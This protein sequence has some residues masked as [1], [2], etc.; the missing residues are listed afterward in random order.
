MSVSS[1]A[2]YEPVI[3]AQAGIHL[4]KAFREHLTKLLPFAGGRIAVALSG[5]ADSMALTL[6]AADWARGNNTEIVAL[7]VDHGLRAESAEE[8]QTVNAWMRERNISH[9]ILTPTHTDSSN[10][11]QE[12]ARAW[13]YDALAEYCREHGILHCL[14][15][16][17]AGDNR[18]TVLHARERGDTADG[19]SGMASVRTHQ[20][21]RFL[22]PLLTMERTDL[23]QL[24]RTKNATWVND[25][26]NDNTRFARV[27]NRQRLNDEPA[28]A[29][30]LDAEIAAAREARTTRDA[31]LASAAIACVK[32]SPLGYAEINLEQWC[33]L[34][35]TLASQLLADVIRTVDG[36]AHRPRGADTLR[37]VQALQTPDMTRRTLQHCE[38]TRTQTTIRI[39]REPARAQAPVTLTGSGTMLWDGRF[40]VSFDVP[41]GEPLTLRALGRD[42][43]KQLGQKLPLA[44][45]S[46]WHLDE[47]RFLPHMNATQAVTLGFAP[48]KALAATPFW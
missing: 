19:E 7:T 45:P 38:I 1:A 12:A 37:L 32:L 26:S 3:P 22:R 46:L 25:P 36:S 16:H 4:E 9:H 6:L 24:L 30:A 27:R 33:A 48:A 15:A 44:T 47:L 41:K 35:P 29:A 28:F 13:R 18:E 23:E 43:I 40:R 14:V 34:E 5:G 17:T 8:A 2:A 31:A 20:G 11:L 21:V 42:G 39:A 10:N